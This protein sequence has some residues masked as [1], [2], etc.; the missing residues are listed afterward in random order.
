MAVTKLNGV[1]VDDKRLFVKEACFD[2][3]DEKLKPKLPRF[4]GD[5]VGGTS[6]RVKSSVINEVGLSTINGHGVSHWN[7]KTPDRYFVQ[8]LRGETSNPSPSKEQ[9]ITIKYVGVGNGWLLRSAVAVM[10]KVVPLS[11]LKLSFSKEYTEEVQFRALGGIYV[12]ITFQNSVERDALIK[13]PWMERWFDRVKPWQGESASLKRFVWL[14]CSGVPLNSWNA[15]TFKRIREVWRHFI[16]LDEETLK[17]LSFAKGKILIATVETSRIEEW[18]R[19]E[20]QGVWYD[21]LVNEESSFVYPEEVGKWVLPMQKADGVHTNMEKT[22]VE[23]GWNPV[24]EEK[25]VEDDDVESHFQSPTNEG[26]GGGR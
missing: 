2:L 5:R 6:Q 25:G 24:S 1:W 23:G 21:V 26:G 14:S 18:I 7:R 10:N 4:Q 17:D 13:G 15:E 19:M 9:D 20:V 8:V 11:M 3:K 22:L 16:L 12:L